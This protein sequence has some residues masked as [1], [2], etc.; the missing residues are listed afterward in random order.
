M[1]EEEEG[2]DGFDKCTRA[3]L[4]WFYIHE[5]PDVFSTRSLVGMKVAWEL[6]FPVA[7]NIIQDV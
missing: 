4:I 1:R 6:L 3:S 7:I 5:G 2:L